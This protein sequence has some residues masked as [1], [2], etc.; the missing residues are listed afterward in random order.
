[1]TILD[2][3]CKYSIRQVLKQ[4][5]KERKQ[6]WVSRKMGLQSNGWGVKVYFRVVGTAL[7]SW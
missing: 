7:I 6:K 2:F 1:L 4:E 5:K 3:T